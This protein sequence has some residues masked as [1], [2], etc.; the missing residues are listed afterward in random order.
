MSVLNLFQGALSGHSDP[1]Q[2][3]DLLCGGVKNN[4]PTYTQILMPV[5]CS[6]SVRTTSDAHHLAEA[7][8]ATAYCT[9][10]VAAVPPVYDRLI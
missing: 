8:A 7:A 4:H 2:P 6:V 3:G 5:T 1:F 9:C 10:T